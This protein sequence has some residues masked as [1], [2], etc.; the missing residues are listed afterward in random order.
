M[1]PKELVARKILWWWM[2]HMDQQYSLTLGRPLAISTAGDCPSPELHLPDPVSQS[3]WNFIVQFSLLGRSILSMPHLANDKIDRYTDDLV[4][5][6]DSLP[7]GLQF[8]ASWLDRDRPLIGW[9]LDVQAAILHA[10]AHNFLILL[11]RRR[12]ETLRRNSENSRINVVYMPADTDCTGVMRGRPRVLESCRALLHAFEFYQTR[13]RAAMICWTMGQMAFNA[14]MLLTLSMLETGETQ[15][16]LPV[17]HAYSTFLE[18]NKLGVHKL[19]GAAV[20]RLGRLMKE[21]RTEDSANETVMGPGG[22]MLLEDPGSHKIGPESYS[23]YTTCSSSP[24]TPQKTSHL[25]QPSKG[26]TQRKRQTRK[27][28]TTRDARVPKSR[29]SSVSKAPRPLADRRFSDSVTPR[30]SQRK[31][32]T[33][34]NPPLSIFTSLPDEHIFASNSSATVKSETLFTPSLPTFDGLAQSSYSSPHPQQAQ[35]M[36]QSHDGISRPH[37][38]AYASAQQRPQQQTQQ[39]SFSTQQHQPRRPHQ[40]QPHQQQANHSSHVG[41]TTHHHQ[42]PPT[43]QASNG[44]HQPFDFSD[45]SA[46]YSSEF[47]DANL[48]SAV[49]AGHTFDE[50]NLNFEHPP[51]SAPPFSMPSDQSF[52][53]VH[54]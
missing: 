16:L 12:S 19:A 24:G 14:S 41:L 22:M 21:F 53:A 10:K 5:L 47:F 31:R 39:P 28:T 18:M 20:E 32:A 34:S 50:H 3:I 40:P 44:D 29:R 51:F 43:P 33:K 27:S 25:G 13:L 49:V 17:Q 42:L 35:D 46:P 15:D 1:M 45:T 26:S 7:L 37:S 6:Q 11:N 52:G 48:P 9:P 23:G 30:P 2:L 36:P 38:R 4:K 54:F 8:D